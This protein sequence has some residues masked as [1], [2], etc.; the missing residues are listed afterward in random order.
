MALS[1]RGIEG[2]IYH[3]KSDSS[4]QTDKQLLANK[5][6]I[7]VVDKEQKRVV[8]IDVAIPADANIRKKEHEKIEKYQVTACHVFLLANHFQ[9]PPLSPS[10]PI[11]MSVIP[12]PWQYLPVIQAELGPLFS[13]SSPFSFSQ[14]LFIVPMHSKA[15]RIGLQA[16]FGPY[17]VTQLLSEAGLQ[18]SPYLSAS[19]LSEH[20]QRERDKKGRKRFKVR[21]LFHK[22]GDTSTQRTCITLHAFKETEEHKASCMTEPPLGICVVTLTLPSEWFK[23]QHP[24]KFHQNVSK[25]HISIHRH[26]RV[27]KWERQQGRHHNH[28]VNQ[29]L[30]NSSSWR[31]HSDVH[32]NTLGAVQRVHRYR[33]GPMRNQVQL[34]YSSFETQDD[35]ELKEQGAAQ[36]QRQL[37]HIKAVTP[38]EEEK[39]RESM[40]KE[41]SCFNGEEEEELHL[42][43]HVMIRYHKGLVLIGRSVRVS[44]NLRDNFSATFVVIRL[45]VK[46]GLISVV[47]QRGSTTE[48][49]AVTLEKS[50][51]SKH[52][53]VS[54]FCHKQNTFKHTNP[55]VL[56]QVA[57][58]SVYGP[59]QSFGVAMAVH[60]YWWVEYSRHSNLRSPHRT[61]A[62]IFSFAD[63]HIFGISPITETNTIIN[64]A[65]LTNQPVSLPVIVLAMSHDG[66][67][68]DVT[69]A[70][71]CHSTN[72]N[73]VKVSGDCSTLYVD[74]S[75]SGLGHTCATVDFH[76]GT[77]NGSVCLE[78]WAPSVPL[79][80]SLADPVLNII[81]GWNHFTDKGCVP[82]YQR[83]SVQ[84]LAQ[85]TAQDSHSGTTY[86]LGSSDWF[87]DVTE[88][89]IN[90]LRIEDPRVVSLDTHNNLI[91]L[92]PGN[93]SIYVISE[94]WDG[95]LAR[96]DITVTSEPVNPG[97]LSV[98]VI[99][100]LGMSLSASPAHPALIT[101]TVT[102]YNSMYNQQQEASV[103]IWLQFSDDTA[104][105]LSSFDDLP[106]FLR[107]SSLA[108]TVVVVTPGPKQHILAQGDGGG[109][110]LLAELL[111]STCTN[112][113]TTSN[114]SNSD[115][116]RVWTDTEDRMRRLAKG[117]G[118]LRVNLDLGL[119]PPVRGNIDDG[120]DFEY[121]TDT[122]VESDSD[123]YVTN[124]DSDEVG[125]VGIDYNGKIINRNWN[126]LENSW[127]VSQDNIERAVL[128]PSQ[129]E[130]PV[131][132]S[133]Q[134]KKVE[135]KEEEREVAQE[136]EVGV[137]AVLSLLFLSAVLILANCLPCAL[138]DRRTSQMKERK[139]IEDKGANDKELDE[140]KK[141]EVG[142]CMAEERIKIGGEV[143]IKQLQEGKYQDD[144]KE[145]EIICC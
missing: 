10:L 51:G 70:V 19:L 104:S 56:K 27:Q 118:W 73:C 33:R 4:F 77:L 79:R 130:V 47:D 125:T 121:I 7:V 123:I 124:F 76:L 50:Q 69:S 15:S 72:E 41:E 109:P 94:Q 112:Q 81:H 131:Y 96:C 71:W 74:G 24:S 40:T 97:D 45:K 142:D 46:K 80:M 89:V 103:S 114:T 60:G 9:A 117:S 132:F 63:R 25:R 86:L 100:G 64:T 49:W 95:M 135:R 6:D 144:V 120:E 140:R 82:V 23:D 12:T 75:E 48:L 18:L 53:L 93:T 5:P 119:M 67:V 137:G 98:Q 26:V 30:R 128:L 36:S 52:D 16:S 55:T 61:S 85:F 83:T 3:S 143:R 141:I 115:Y 2:K 20:V 90:S 107:L 21:T 65:I 38:W 43:S 126:K 102:A 136:L 8:G 35:P 113:Q 68:S 66:K 13:N 87:V 108:E 57:C 110:L 44:V 106:Y 37:F 138:Q 32:G 1:T 99:S 34:Y 145:A 22:Q 54:I 139:V 111:A 11:H 105:L 59:K 31:Y 116:G 91:G 14:S 78:V 127:M 88:L 39:E 101:A 42:D 29:H 17:S 84:V 92:Q 122:L 133:S 62:S 58:L 28:F 134:E 129:E